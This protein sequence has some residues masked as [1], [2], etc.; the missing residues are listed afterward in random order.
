MLTRLSDFAST[1]N[2]RGK[3]PLSVALVVTDTARI[4]GL[5]LDAASLLTGSA[6]QV[7]GLSGKKV[8]SI[9]Q[10]HGVARELSR[11]GGRTSRGS[12]SKM[13]AYVDFLNELHAQ[14]TVDLE[15]VEAFWVQKVR[16]FFAGKP[17]KLRL[18][19]SLGVRTMV[20]DLIEQ[21]E[22]RQ[23]EAQGTMI[24][25]TILQHLVG[26]KLEVALDE[27]LD[28]QHHGASVA[29]ASERGGDFDL[30]DTSIHVSTAPGEALLRKCKRNLDDGRRPI[31]VTLRD[32]VALAEGLAKNIGIG[33]RVDVLEVE[34]F[35]ATN[36]YE[37]GA[38]EARSRRD[39]VADIVKR[40]N[41]IIAEH[42]TDPSLGI[43]FASPSAP[44]AAPAAPAAPAPA[45]AE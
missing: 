41:A 15:A 36:I 4:M 31:I 45:P 22:A 39:T 43:D 30:N 10:R 37:L 34:Q 27:R 11:E 2:F 16:E 28:V 35:L 1:R 42:E 6:G 3:G 44:A 7:L 14:G 32:G 17:F 13:R 18:D 29:D 12:I 38:F 26:A 5:P 8:Q 40:Y 33:E 23:R 19:Q 24:V 25:G 9:L 21:A 20:R